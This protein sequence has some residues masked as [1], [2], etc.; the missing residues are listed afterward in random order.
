MPARNVAARNVAGTG[1]SWIL[2]LFFKQVELEPV[3]I[4]P[5]SL[6]LLLGAT[7]S[8]WSPGEQSSDCQET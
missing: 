7:A 2:T 5:E 6:K 3:K 8:S 4:S 1:S